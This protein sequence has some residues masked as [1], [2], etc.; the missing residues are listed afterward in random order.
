MSIILDPDQARCSVGPDIGSN[1]LQRLSADG[2]SRQRVNQPVSLFTI[3]K[4]ELILNA[5]EFIVLTL[6]MMVNF[7]CFFAVC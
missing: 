4:P 7:S 5:V 6:C 1:C 2:A 3:R